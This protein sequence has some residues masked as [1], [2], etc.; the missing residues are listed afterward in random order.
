MNMM[1]KKTA[2]AL[3]MGLALGLS[4]C[5][6]G[7]GGGSSGDSASS[8]L[9]KNIDGVQSVLDMGMTRDSNGACK[10]YGVDPAVAD[11]FKKAGTNPLAYPFLDL[12]NAE[13]AYARGLNGAGVTVAVWDYGIST[14]HREFVGGKIVH[15]AT[16]P[17]DGDHGTMVASMASGW[18]IGV[19]NQATLFDLHGTNLAA[20]YSLN[21]AAVF[22]MS[23]GGNDF[24]WIFPNVPDNVLFVQSAGNE[25]I[26]IDERRARGV[27][28]VPYDSMVL[29]PRFVY[30]GVVWINDPDSP[31]MGNFPGDSALL[32]ST[33]I[34]VPAYGAIVADTTSD[35]AYVQMG[36][37]SMAAPAISGAGAIIKQARPDLNAAQ[38]RDILLKSANKSFSVEY[39]RNDCGAKKTTNC[40]LYYYGQGLLDI[41]AA[42]KL[43]GVN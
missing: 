24:S 34:T 30:A 7:G 29:A 42:L 3:A 36:G 21:G 6:G 38:I 13:Y 43:A 25:G 18:T 32:Q 1:M 4:A 16:I 20:P 28:V 40:G 5:G 19:A 14:T 27:T 22:N 39:Q 35:T 41:A 11:V 12:V 31:P 9:C 2:L 8:D 23:L 26:T 10:I 37:T 17:I 33:F 15:P